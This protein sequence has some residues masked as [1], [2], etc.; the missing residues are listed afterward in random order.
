MFLLVSLAVVAVIGLVTIGTV[1]EV[2]V[3]H[4]YD[5][6]ELNFMDWL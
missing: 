5:H 4:T 3:R 6:K 1:S 2:D